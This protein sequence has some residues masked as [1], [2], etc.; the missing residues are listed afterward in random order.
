M[1][2]AVTVASDQLGLEIT[3]DGVGIRATDRSSGL[4]NMRRRAERHGGTFHLV[5]HDPNGTRLTWTV[6]LSPAGTPSTSTR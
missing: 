3:D 4:A 1:V 6:P 2:L 5:G